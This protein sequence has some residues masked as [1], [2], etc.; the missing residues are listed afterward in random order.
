M[1]FCKVF[2]RQILGRIFCENTE[3]LL[4]PDIANVISPADLCQ[5][6]GD[7]VIKPS[8]TA[9]LCKDAKYLST[10]PIFTA[11][12]D[13]GGKAAA[14]ATRALRHSHCSQLSQ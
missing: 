2:F 12:G 1:L 7:W 13:F 9:S 14:A 6:D 3:I 5:M 8:V 4:S 11:N 10:L